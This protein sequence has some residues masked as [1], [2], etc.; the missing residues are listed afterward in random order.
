MSATGTADMSKTTFSMVGASMRQKADNPAADPIPLVLD[1][2]GT[3]VRGN[4]L[5]ET[6]LAFVRQFPLQA[7]MLLVWLLRGRAALKQELARRAG[8]DVES[9]PLNHE[10]IAYAAA[11][12]EL[13]RPV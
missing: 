8:I 10:L 3:V 11:E 2:D 7:F 5:V 6:A 1:L 13:G 9:L 12:N 4:L